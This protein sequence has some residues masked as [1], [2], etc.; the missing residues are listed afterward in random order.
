MV[1]VVCCGGGSGYNNSCHGRTICQVEILHVT[2]HL[3]C[4]LSIGNG[5]G[6]TSFSSR[7]GRSAVVT[8]VVV[9][10]VID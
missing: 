5:N 1:I 4:S 6:T 9:V 8:H 3:L 10:I 7:T 2:T